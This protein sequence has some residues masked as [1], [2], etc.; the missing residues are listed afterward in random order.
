[1]E[2]M[3]AGCTNLET[4]PLID[5]ANVTNMSGMFDG[6]ISLISI[7]LLDT[8]KV[9]NMDDMF[10][11]CETLNSIPLFDTSRA[12]SMNGTFT[13]CV[14][15]GS[16]ALAL[17]NQASSQASPPSDTT[18]CFSDCG[19]NTETGRAELAQ[20]PASWGGTGS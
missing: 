11:E 1:M 19:S 2:R 4:I 5:T 13:Y 7:P 8:S 6:C 18:A 14:N 17:Y 15:V 16:G 10:N 20:I 12:E 9:T 3:F